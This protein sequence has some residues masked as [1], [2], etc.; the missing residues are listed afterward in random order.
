[1]APSIEAAAGSVVAVKVHGR[2][3]QLVPRGQGPGMPGWFV[4]AQFE[5]GTTFTLQ[6]PDAFTQAQVVEFAEQVSYHP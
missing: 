4:Q 6:A 3:A 1:M 5:A 2:P